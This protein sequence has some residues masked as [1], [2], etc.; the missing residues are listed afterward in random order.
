MLTNDQPPACPSCRSTETVQTSDHLD[1]KLF[2]CAACEHTWSTRLGAIP[3]KT[4]EKK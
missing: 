3:K 4:K 1:E 2:F